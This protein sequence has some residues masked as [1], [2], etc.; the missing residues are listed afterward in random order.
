MLENMADVPIPELWKN[1]ATNFNDRNL[2]NLNP[3]TVDVPNPVL[4]L[5]KIPVHPRLN[6]VNWN[7]LSMESNGFGIDSNTGYC[8][9]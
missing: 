5:T 4:A 8:A 3:I 1:R 6:G 9:L 7:I 2:A